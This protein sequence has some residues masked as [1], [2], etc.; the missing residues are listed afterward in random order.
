MSAH[1]IVADQPSAPL[2]PHKT[3]FLGHNCMKMWPQ[4]FTWIYEGLKTTRHG[5]FGFFFLDLQYFSFF[6]YFT[7][8]AF[9]KS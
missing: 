6:C 5:L 4:N 7:S 3:K 1:W 9:K 8:P 2:L